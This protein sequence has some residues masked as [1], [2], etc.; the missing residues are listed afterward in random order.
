MVDGPRVGQQRGWQFHAPRDGQEEVN[1]QQC[2]QP[3]ADFQDAACAPPA[4]L[5]R[6]VKRSVFVLS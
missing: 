6:V 1:Q 5:L 2:Q 4:D 3:A